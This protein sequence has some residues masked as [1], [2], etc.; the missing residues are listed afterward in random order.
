MQQFKSARIKIEAI[1]DISV[2][3]TYYN[4]MY[5]EKEITDLLNKAADTGTKIF[6]PVNNMEIQKFENYIQS[7]VAKIINIPDA[8]IVFNPFSWKSTLFPQLRGCG[9]CLKKKK[10]YEMDINTGN[11]KEADVQF[12]T[13]GVIFKSE[14]EP[15]QYKIFKAA[16][17]PDYIDIS[18]STAVAQAPE[19]GMQIKRKDGNFVFDNGKVRFIINKYGDILSC[20]DSAGKIKI[21][22]GFKAILISSTNLPVEFDQNEVRLSESGMYQAKLQLVNRSKLYPMFEL[23]REIS[24]SSG[25]YMLENKINILRTANT[26]SSIGGLKISFVMSRDTVTVDGGIFCKTGN[27]GIVTGNAADY[28]IFNTGKKSKKINYNINLCVLDNNAVNE[29]RYGIM[30]KNFGS[31]DN[32]TVQL[33]KLSRQLICDLNV[34][35]VEYPAA[36]MNPQ[37]R[38][39][40]PAF[41]MN[42]GMNLI[43]RDTATVTNP[44]LFPFS[45]PFLKLSE[46]NN[47]VITGLVKADNNRL[48]VL[49]LNMN[50][51]INTAVTLKTLFKIQEPVTFSN[52]GAFNYKLADSDTLDFSLPGKGSYEIEFGLTP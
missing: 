27:Y 1:R 10:Y 41:P 40:M 19:T 35:P 5:F 52:T 28:E 34:S 7:R 50:E 30:L 17:N 24:L 36:V 42:N 9:S 20:S 22:P 8:Y 46:G 2:I 16:L 38:I 37:Q 21:K 44:E 39:M 4:I 45:N 23:S 51:N 11:D 6:I 29:F 43:S 18:I 47:V 49:L 14:F 13:G 26:N 25:S 32:E 31:N 12:V 3:N 33:W 15:Y 48:K